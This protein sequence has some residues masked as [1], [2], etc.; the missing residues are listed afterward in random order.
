MS[1]NHPV[2]TRQWSKR[3][4]EAHLKKR[5]YKVTKTC[6]SSLIHH[7]INNTW[8][9]VTSWTLW[10]EQLKRFLNKL[11]SWQV[12]EILVFLC[13][14]V[15]KL[16]KNKVETLQSVLVSVLS[17]AWTSSTKVWIWS[18]YANEYLVV[19]ALLLIYC[20]TPRPPQVTWVSGAG[21][22]LFGCLAVMHSIWAWIQHNMCTFLLYSFML[23]PN[24]SGMRRDYSQR[25]QREV[26]K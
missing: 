18:V 23:P 12:K 17:A 9:V 2:Q 21:A 6:L 22:G 20:N 4:L 13:F 1:V 8:R 15:L 24:I 26:D 11:T 10:T 19:P 14:W 25:Q 5:Q 7:K 3:H 16:K